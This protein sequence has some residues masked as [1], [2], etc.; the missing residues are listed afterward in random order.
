MVT[1]FLIG[2]G[3]CVAIL[4]LF[5]GVFRKQLRDMRNRE[6]SPYQRLFNRKGNNN[7]GR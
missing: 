1:G 6:N 2:L 3:I 4:V 7:N 5:L